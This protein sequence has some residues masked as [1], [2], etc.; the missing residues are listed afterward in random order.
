MVDV[1]KFF[2][3]NVYDDLRADPD[4]INPLLQADAIRFLY[5]FRSQVGSLRLLRLHGAYFIMRIAEQGTVNFCAASTHSTS[6]IPELRMLY[7]RSHQYRADFGHQT[8]S[9]THVG[10]SCRIFVD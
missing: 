4:S 9:A 1:V 5:T 8:R 2:S 7:L 10:F 3:E 6:R